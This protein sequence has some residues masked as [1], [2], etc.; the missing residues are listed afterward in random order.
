MLK[1]KKTVLIADDEQ[2]ICELLKKIID[3]DGLKLCFIGEYY[4]GQALYQA[5][6]EKKPDIVITDISMPQMDGIELIGRVRREGIPC[7]FV[8]VSGYR[9]FEYAHNALKYDVEDYIL[10]PVDADELNHTLNKLTLKIAEE[11]NQV[12]DRPAAAHNEKLLKRF[13]LNNGITQ[14][15][16]NKLTLEQIHK[17]Y[18]INFKEGLFQIIYIKS[19]IREQTQD[20]AENSSSIQNKIAVTFQDMFGEIC[21]CILEEQSFDTIKIGMNYPVENEGRINN[22]LKEYFGRIQNYA[23]LFKGYQ[24]TVGVGASYDHPACFLKSKEEAYAAIGSR[25]VLGCDQIIYWKN[26]EQPQEILT[27][28][29]KKELFKNLEKTFELMEKER[30]KELMGGF[31]RYARNHFSSSSLFKLL[32]EILELFLQTKERLSAGRLNE[33]Y[34]RKQYIYGMQSAVSLLD[35]QKAVIRPV[36]EAMDQLADFVEQQ[37]KKPVR[38]AFVYV[39][40]NYAKQIHLEDV[41]SYVNLNPVY[42][43]NVFKRETGENFT[44]YLTNYRMKIARELL[45]ATNDSMN[46]IAEKT[47]YQDAR[48]FSKLFKKSVGIKPS[49]Y[50]KIYG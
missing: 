16:H 6:L 47:G 36:S 8:I 32:E 15:A 25:I 37:N 28:G 3:W 22:K 31:F 5:I 40:E 7:H 38:M 26:L 17:E 34:I 35:L 43:S 42:F 27:D 48:Y 49:E 29:E 39:E 19:D 44:D 13:F 4:T 18:G 24:L 10:K 2:L 50:R 45:C 14:L 1:N 33:D 46:E 30:F 23:D 41:A 12:E 9:Q 21:T 11:E 20:Y